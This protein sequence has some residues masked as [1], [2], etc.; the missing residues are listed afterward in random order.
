[1]DDLKNFLTK[2]WG[3]I[4][5]GIIATILLC[6]GAY[7]LL[8]VIVIVIALSYLFTLHPNCGLSCLSSFQSSHFIPSTVHSTSLSL[9]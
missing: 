9:Q 7:R 2:Y 6:T 8:V 5:G 3:A 1:M 4:L